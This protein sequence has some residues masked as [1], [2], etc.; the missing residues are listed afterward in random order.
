[1]TSIPQWE[2]AI[3]TSDIL[4]IVETC[5]IFGKPAERVLFF[6]IAL[7]HLHNNQQ[8]GQIIIFIADAVAEKRHNYLHS[9][10][11]VLIALPPVF[12]L[13]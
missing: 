4:Y 8:S 7:V 12:T 5:L 11:Q 3:S 10:E 1:V 6:L 13:L 9:N 2:T